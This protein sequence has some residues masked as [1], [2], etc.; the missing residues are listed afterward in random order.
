M[1]PERRHLVIDL[2]TGSVVRAQVGPIGW[3]VLKAIAA[4]APPGRTV[5]E[6]RCSSRSLAAIVGVSKD[7][8]ARALRC[9]IDVGTVERVD[10][11]EERSGRFSSTTYRVELAS[12]GLTVVTVSLD[13]DP[14]GVVTCSVRTDP[15]TPGDQLSLL[16]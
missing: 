13:A 10:H 12:A 8:V 14:A 5:V 9:L 11:R 1:L 7:S 6:A 16:A 3:L 15:R 4:D 2:D